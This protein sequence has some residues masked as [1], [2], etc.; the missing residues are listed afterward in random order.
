MTSPVMKKEFD[1]IAMK[2]EAQ[3]RIYDEIKGMSVEEQI[4]YFQKA[5]RSSRFR[6][7]WE[8]AD[9]SSGGGIKQ[10]S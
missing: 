5:V 2:R 1:C 3:A 10:V 7:W 9:R 6:E 8:K 4:G